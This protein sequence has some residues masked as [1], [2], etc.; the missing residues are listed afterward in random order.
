LA[1]L[2][3]GSLDPGRG[4]VLLAARVGTTRLIDNVVLGVDAPP[5]VE[6]AAHDET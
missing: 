2:T 5:R 1:P 3:A 4:T 6:P